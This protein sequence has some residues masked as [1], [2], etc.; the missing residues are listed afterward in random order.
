MKEFKIFLQLGDYNQ[1]IPIPS[2]LIAYE[3]ES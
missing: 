2:D 3:K 1:E